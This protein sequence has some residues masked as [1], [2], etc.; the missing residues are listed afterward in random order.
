MPRYIIRVEMD[1]VNEL[2]NDQQL[3]ILEHLRLIMK[4]F[5]EAPELS[6]VRI[7]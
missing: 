4:F 6:I 3:A 2:P 1:T 5:I 7:H